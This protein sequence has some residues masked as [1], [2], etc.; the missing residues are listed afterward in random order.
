MASV[1]RS[2]QRAVARAAALPPEDQDALAAVM[3]AEIDDTRIW[4]ER[5][6]D[7]RSPTVLRRLA[8]GGARRG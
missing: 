8:G 4:E 2:F 3:Q 5:F 6:A 1:T 7:D